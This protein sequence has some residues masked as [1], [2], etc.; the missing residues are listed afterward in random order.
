MDFL[1]A[2]DELNTELLNI[3]SLLLAAVCAQEHVD[4]R[5]FLDLVWIAEKKAEVGKNLLDTRLSEHRK[6]CPTQ[7]EDKA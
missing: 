2:D 5:I 4:D 7:P 1:D 6:A 3:E